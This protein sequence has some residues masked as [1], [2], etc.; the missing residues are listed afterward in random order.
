MRLDSAYFKVA[1]ESVEAAAELGA[2][3][4]SKLGSTAAT[5]AG[6]GAA[7]GLAVE[8]NGPVGQ[9][10]GKSLAGK[11]IVAIG[12]K[13]GKD[14]KD[15]VSPANDEITASRIWKLLG[16]K[17]SDLLEPKLE[18]SA[19]IPRLNP[20]GFLPYGIHVTNWSNLTETFAINEHRAQLTR[21]MLH[22]LHD[23]KA[24]GFD[25]VYLGGSFITKKPLPNDFDLTY[26]SADKTRDMLYKNLP[27]MTDRGLMKE[28]YGGEALPNM[29]EYFLQ[30]NGRKIGIVKI[31]MSS[32]PERSA[33][34]PAF[35]VMQQHGG[36]L[37]IR[38]L[39]LKEREAARSF[40]LYGP[41]II[42]P[43]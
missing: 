29:T 8:Q 38:R 3:V 9:F 41:G 22:A 12:E 5:R 33:E 20:E 31:D 24:Q 27:L 36:P 10:V 34:S 19:G 2:E 42:P 7:K 35:S 40:D 23:L 21:G 15:A 1:R 11:N 30:H 25:D 14:A 39:F 18:I 28:A 26:K 37:A 17:E 32:L 6:V 4:W 13:I 43:R 16:R